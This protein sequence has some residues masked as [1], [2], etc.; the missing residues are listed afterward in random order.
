MSYEN[1]NKYE[2]DLIELR[3]RDFSG[4]MYDQNKSNEI[5][6]LIKKTF[7]QMQESAD[8]IEKKYFNKTDEPTYLNGA[9]EIIKNIISGKSIKSNLELKLD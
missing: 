7:S 4:T 2:E 9:G 6:K 8:Y 1:I 5:S 3:K